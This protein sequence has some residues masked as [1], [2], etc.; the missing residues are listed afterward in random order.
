MPILAASCWDLV[1][2][3]SSVNHCFVLQDAVKTSHTHTEDQMGGTADI[4]TRPFDSVRLKPR[5][6]MIYVIQISSAI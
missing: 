4:E 3:S 2:T 5:E 6:Y 1:Q